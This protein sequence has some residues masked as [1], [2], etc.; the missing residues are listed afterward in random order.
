MKAVNR[1][2]C[3]SCFYI[4]LLFLAT[5]CHDNEL[6][7]QLIGSWEVVS[8][9]IMEKP[10]PET[11]PDENRG[12]PN[13]YFTIGDGWRFTDEN[14]IYLSGAITSQLSPP[15]YF[16]IVGDRLHLF[17]RRKNEKY[18]SQYPPMATFKTTMDSDSTLLVQSL[19]SAQHENV[20]VTLKKQ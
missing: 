10:L 19:R 8:S 16:E 2:A 6:E 14:D 5:S 3:I 18:S 1:F 11:A 7:Q 17:L 15:R 12:N 20:Q 4:C 9:E 13:S